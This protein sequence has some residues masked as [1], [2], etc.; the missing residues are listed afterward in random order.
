MSLRDVTPEA[1][2]DACD[3]PVP[4]I[5]EHIRAQS[6]LVTPR[7]MLSRATAAQRGASLVINL[8][9]SE[10]AARETFG[11]VAEQLQHA[12]DMARGGGHG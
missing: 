11:V 8:P 1:T 10:K 6:S 9:G 2:T 5:A 4:G 7:A 12:V 3:R